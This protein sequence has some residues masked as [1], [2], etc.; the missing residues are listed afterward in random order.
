MPRA[1]TSVFDARRG[2]ASLARSHPSVFQAGYL[3]AHAFQIFPIQIRKHDA[4]PI[5]ALCDDAPPR[6][7]DH[8][9]P[10]GRASA[11][12]TAPLGGCDDPGLRFDR[13]RPEEHGPV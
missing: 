7:D 1:T 6:I 2:S 4:Y 3:R 11:G 5:G 9:M 8:R 10:E 13:A 12:V